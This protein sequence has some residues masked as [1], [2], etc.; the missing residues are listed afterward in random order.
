M[1]YNP[2]SKENRKIVLLGLF[3]S[4]IWYSYTYIANFLL[5]SIKGYT[6]PAYIVNIG[7]VF[8]VLILN[9]WLGLFL[10]QKINERTC[11]WI[12]EYEI[13]QHKITK[14]YYCPRCAPNRSPLAALNDESWFC[15]K[16][17][18]GFG[19]SDGGAFAIDWCKI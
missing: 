13:W 18:H 16:C 11:T 3:T 6:V 5:K 4:A 14:L 2:L 7:F 12:Q 17:D 9:I 19:K 1:S 15:N 8:V 10:N